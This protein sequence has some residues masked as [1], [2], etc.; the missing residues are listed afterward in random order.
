LTLKQNTSLC[1][2]KLIFNWLLK[3]IKENYK[4]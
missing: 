1:S 2:T 4:K 3:I